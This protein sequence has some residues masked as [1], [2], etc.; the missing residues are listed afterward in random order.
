MSAAGPAWR[1]RRTATAFFAFAGIGVLAGMFGLGAGWANVPVFNLLMGV[2]LKLSVGTSGFL[3]SVSDTSAAW[4]YINR[5][6]VLP[7][8]VAPSIIG[9]MLGAKIGARL[10]RVAPA[11]AIRRV[12]IGLLFVAGT[13]A[14]LKGLGL[15]N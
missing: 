8:L 12:V 6:A 13:R 9:V 11:A 14:L 10:L 5:G 7:M 2:P 3:L 1:V 4:I 15:W